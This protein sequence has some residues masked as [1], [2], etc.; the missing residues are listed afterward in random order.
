MPTVLST[1]LYPFEPNLPQTCYF[2]SRRHNVGT[3]ILN[4]ILKIN[5]FFQNK[6]PINKLLI[7]KTAPTVF[8]ICDQI[9]LG[10]LYDL[11]NNP[12]PTKEHVIK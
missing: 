12:F 11:L 5:Y 1:P 9:G 7:K 4:K 2:G 6:T 10:A 8:Y 3:R